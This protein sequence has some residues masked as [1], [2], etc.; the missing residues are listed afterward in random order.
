MSKRQLGVALDDFALKEQRQYINEN[1][2]ETLRRHHKRLIKTKRGE[3]NDEHEGGKT[4]M[5][6][7]GDAVQEVCVVEGDRERERAEA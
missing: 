3:D 7:T 1:I 2:K 6:T 5:I 4:F